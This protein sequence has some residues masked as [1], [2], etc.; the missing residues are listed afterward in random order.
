MK[1][2]TWISKMVLIMGI[3]SILRLPV[4]AQEVGEIS[5][6]PPAAA[7]E[8]YNA[9]LELAGSQQFAE[10]SL[11]FEEALALAPTF[12]AARYNLGL[13]YRQLGEKEKAVEELQQSLS[14]APQPAM[15][16]RI[17]GELLADLVRIDEAIE[18]YEAALSLDETQTDLHYA[19]ATLLH[20]H[21]KTKEDKQR[22]IEAYE[23]AIEKAPRHSSARSAYSSLA[24]LYY[25]AGDKEKALH[26]Y[27]MACRYDA[28]NADLHYNRGVLLNQMSRIQD[29]VDALKTS[30]ELESPNG[31]AQYA[32]AEIYYSK[33]HM[34]EKAIDAYEAAA[35]D[36]H[37]SK[38]TQAR[39]HA[40][41]IKEYLEK[42][43]EAE[44]EA[45][46]AMEEGDGSQ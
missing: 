24:Q 39:D 37:F 46:A 28:S 21:A 14:G 42:K 13:I 19:I 3:L 23:A 1:N 15:A 44:A 20:R 36:P 12:T 25:H 18:Q 34:D 38:A 2:R 35:A 43:R 22:T 6:P 8:L 5:V 40:K 16:H 30:I 7:V 29:A 11:K 41:M 10:A 31:K 33:L 17:L 32:L 27:D 4:K 45:D 9:G 26:N